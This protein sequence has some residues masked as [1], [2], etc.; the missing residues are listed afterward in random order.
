MMLLPSDVGE[1]MSTPTIKS[2]KS[3]SSHQLPPRKRLFNESSINKKK[4][5]M[6]GLQEIGKMGD[7]IIGNVNTLVK[8]NRR[9][10]ALVRSLEFQLSICTC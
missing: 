5:N 6:R 8:E 2:D 9:L 7:G 1:Q 4:Q 3:C 10:H